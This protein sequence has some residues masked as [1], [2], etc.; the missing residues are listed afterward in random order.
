MGDVY[1]NFLIPCL[2]ISSIL[3]AGCHHNL[4]INDDLVERRM[5]SVFLN[6]DQNEVDLNALTDF[7]W[8]KAYIF[9]PYTTSE[10]M[11]EKLGFK[12]N[13]ATGIDYRDDINLIV[14]VKD[15]KVVKYIELPRKYGDFASGD[16]ENGITPENSIV[17]VEIFD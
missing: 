5:N 11:T 16:I 14:F 15:K 17:T 6:K 13:N 10:Y 3:F 7:S 4:E 9:P 1:I 8:E 12:W 2:I